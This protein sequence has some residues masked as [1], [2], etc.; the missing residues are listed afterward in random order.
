MRSLLIYLSFVI[1]I[2]SENQIVSVSVDLSFSKKEP[3]ELEDLCLK[4]PYHN[5]VEP[6]YFVPILRAKLKE[7]GDKFSFPSRC[8][9]KNIVYFKEMSKDK[10]TLTLENFNKTDTWCSELFIFH[11]S[12]HNYFQFIAFQGTHD[13]VLKRIT[14]DDKDE[15]KVN[16]IKLY[17]FCLG[18]VNTIKALLKTLQSFYGGL[19]KD[20]KAKN[21]KFRPT[22]PRDMEKVNLR[23][24]DLFCHYRPERRNNTIVNFDKSI[25]KSGDFLVISRI[26]GLD[27][28]IMLGGGGRAGHSAVCGW[29][30]DELY[31][32]ESQSGWY[33][34]RDGIQK[35]KWE[36]W[37]QWA[38]TADFNVA[39]L[40]LREEYREKFDMN[41]AL[42]WFENEVEGLP[43]GYHNFIPT[44][45]DTVDKNFPFFTTA[46]ITEFL[47]AVI[48]YFYPPGSDLFITD[49]MNI[50]LGTTGLTFQQAIAEAARQGKSLEQ[51]IAEPEKEGIVYRDG[52]NLVCSCFVVAFWKHG[53][54]F[55]DID[56][57]PNEFSPRDVYQIDIFDKNFQK[58][59]ECIDDN[60]DLPFCQVMGKFVF[61]LDETYS[62]I[63]PYDHMNERCS[64]QGPDFIREEGC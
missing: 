22:I 7:V 25:I 59:Q 10:I 12:A 63:K 54:L 39:L 16:G 28:M 8:F 29:I 31:V 60:P 61:E 49:L 34:P 23:I 38:H 52:I 14:Q 48:S 2:L 41:K 5:R 35:N 53:G 37:I 11:S 40:P 64:S 3:V 1:L 45:I 20:P 62:S 21:P 6:Y 55:G 17:G 46:E 47:F 33:W 42:D 30:G 43:Y 13:I 56:L 24:L 26:D 15:I 51:L 50:R 19:G 32:F 9:K 18:F 58:P 4:R 27:P 44:W 57:S 36:D